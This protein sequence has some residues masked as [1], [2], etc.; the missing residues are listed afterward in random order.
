[1]LLG[2]I[3]PKRLL[4]KF[5]C[6]FN[7]RIGQGLKGSKHDKNRTYI[8]KIKNIGEGDVVGLSTDAKT[9]ICEGFLSHNTTT[10]QC[11]HISQAEDGSVHIDFVGKSGVDWHI[12]VDDAN[13][14]KSL[15]ELKGNREPESKLLY[16][17]ERS[18]VV[19]WL[20]RFRVTAKDFRT[21]HASNYFVEF[22]KKSIM[23]LKRK[24]QKAVLADIIARVATKLNNKPNTCRSKYIMPVLMEHWLM[25]GKF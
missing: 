7:L 18:D 11:K 17:V 16:D 19:K 23:P 1:M 10:L 14:A 5:L 22:A 21:Y 20:G 12:K 9:Y 24:E 25:G 3:R 13:V 8:V 4:D 15:L 2:S 6:N